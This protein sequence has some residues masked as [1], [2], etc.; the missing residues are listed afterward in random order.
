MIRKG[1]KAMKYKKTSAFIVAIIAVIVLTEAVIKPVFFVKTSSVATESTDLQDDFSVIL[2]NSLGNLSISSDTENTK[3][4]PQGYEKYLS[5]DKNELYFSKD[6][7]AIALLNKQSGDI[8]FSNPDQSVS[9]DTKSQFKVYYSDALGVAKAM[10]SYT[11]CA[12]NGNITFKIEKDKLSV[13]YLLSEDS[14]STN[15][16]PNIISAERFD[17]FA[18]KLSSSE[19]AALTS[20]YVFL[21]INESDD[22]EYNKEIISEYPAVKKYDIYVLNT[23]NKR[24]LQKILS[25]FEKAGYTADD[26]KKDFSDNGLEEVSQSVNFTVVLDYKLKNG[27]L[28]LDIDSKKLQHPSNIP[29]EKIEIMKFF[30]AADNQDDGYFLLPD[31]SGSIIR[32]NNQKTNESVFSLPVY[33]NDSCFTVDEQRNITQKC[34]FPIVGIRKNNSALIVT[35]E[36]GESLADIKAEVSGMSSEY[37]VAYFTLNTVRN[38]QESVNIK[39]TNTLKEKKPYSG[40]YTLRYTPVPDENADYIKMAQCYRKQ[41]INSGWLS[42]EKQTNDYTVL[43]SLLGSVTKSKSFLGIKYDSAVAL[44]SFKEAEKIAEDLTKNGIE[45]LNFQYYGWANAGIRQSSPDKIK[46]SK[47]LGDKKSWLSLNS[48][49]NDKNIPMYLNVS[50]ISINEGKEFNVKK[51]AVK[52]LNGASARIYPFNYVNGYK[53]TDITPLYLISPNALNGKIEGFIKKADELNINSIS[54]DDLG[55]IITSDFNTKSVVNRVDSQDKLVEAL[56]GLSEKQTMALSNPNAYALKNTVLAYDVPTTDS[57]F[58]ITDGSVPFYQAVIRGSVNYTS[59]PINY[60]SNNRFAFLRAIEYGSGLNYFVN[61]HPT[62]ELKNTEYNIYNR[63]TYSDWSEIISEDAKSAS[64][65]ENL[66]SKEIIGHTCLENGIYKTDYEG[67]MFTIVNYTD[68][69]YLYDGITVSAEDFIFS[70]GDV[71]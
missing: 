14:I 33:G 17:S 60:S 24:Q 20:N 52:K 27:S 56:G 7:G 1:I 6:N 45:G 62:N 16:V 26:L 40:T 22:E 57:N 9:P 59:T 65:L 53:K 35:M 67:G 54:S 34:A 66:N 41:L 69:E 58:K 49:I 37:N 63:G 23:S 39:S 61:Y 18:N 50:F 12:L 42:A 5:D 4:I 47:S 48:Y 13:E 11:Y 32:F 28:Y 3:V 51:D 25:L 31:G 43:I 15:D 36:K 19:K 46:I 21:S 68:S 70:G 8:W 71:T 29:I 64:L 38:Q 44:T 10:D 2:P 30:G 55:R